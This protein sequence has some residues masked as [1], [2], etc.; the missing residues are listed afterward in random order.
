MKIMTAFRTATLILALLLPAV[1]ATPALAQMCGTRCDEGE[2][3]TEAEG[4][5]CIPVP[6]PPT[7]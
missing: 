6:P 3:W 5:T 1:L 2:M 7:S 4:G